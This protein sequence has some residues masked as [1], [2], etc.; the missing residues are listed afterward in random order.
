MDIKVL[1][2][3]S[4]ETG[5]VSIVPTAGKPR[6]ILALLAVYANQVLPVPT[7]M[8]EIWGSEMPRSALTTLQ[9]Y[10]LQLRRRLT[11]ALGPDALYGSKDVLVTRH[12]GYLLQVQPGAVDVHEYDRL[13]AEGRK[14]ADEGD[15]RSASR[16]YREALGLWRG[17]ALVDV[18]VGP[19]LEI[20]LVR[21]EES[22]LG[23]LER[24][25][26]AELMLG[27]HAELVSELT[28]LTRRHP[29]HEGLHAQC[30]AAL[31][32]SGRQWQA[33]EV[34]QALRGRLVDELGL[35]PSPRLQR[36]HQAVLSGDPALEFA[37]EQRRPVLDLFAA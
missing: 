23:V 12:G 21:L 17:P 8:E 9:T 13:V 22:R 20:E 3:L 6:Q 28:A 29:L 18:K 24:R 1:G 33:L 30:M 36:L 5:G 26:D 19:M 10:I 37:H 16:L 2:P 25:I 35:E 34:Y 14:A 11:A 31:Y 15:A 32:R 4:A 7:L 27:Q